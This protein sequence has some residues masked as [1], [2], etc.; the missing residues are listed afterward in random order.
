MDVDTF[1]PFSFYVVF[2]WY[3]YGFYGFFN[4]LSL[5]LRTWIGTSIE[6]CINYTRKCFVYSKHINC[7]WSWPLLP[8]LYFQNLDVHILKTSWLNI[9]CVISWW[10]YWFNTLLGFW[11][12]M[13]SFISCCSCIETII[14]MLGVD[15]MNAHTWAFGIL[16][17]YQIKHWIKQ[18]IKYWCLLHYKDHMWLYWKVRHLE[19]MLRFCL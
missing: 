16:H 3:F 4:G 7:C 9:W 15:K 2:L 12:Q 17:M 19:L 18:W 5:I 14:T 8:K 6:T 10:D 11:Q 1:Y 13:S